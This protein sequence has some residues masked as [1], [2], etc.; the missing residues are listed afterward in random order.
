LTPMSGMVGK[1]GVDG[2]E[3][4]LHDRYPRG[5]TAGT[6]S[7]RGDEVGYEVHDFSCDT[8]RQRITACGRRTLRSCPATTDG[9]VGRMLTNANPGPVCSDR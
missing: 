9:R 4:N 8:G 1:G 7:G 5:I 6:S 2:I 3:A